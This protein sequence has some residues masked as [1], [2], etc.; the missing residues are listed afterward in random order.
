[1]MAI[2]RPKEDPTGYAVFVVQEQDG[3]H[4][5]RLRKVKLGDTVGNMIAIVDGVQLGERVITTGATQ[6]VDGAPVQIMP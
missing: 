6:V 2:V 5:A 1:M 3:K 4:V